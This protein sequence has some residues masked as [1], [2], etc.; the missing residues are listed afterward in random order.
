M[1]IFDYVY[2][3][4]YKCHKINANRGESYID[5][6]DWVKNEKTIKNPIN[7]EDNKCFQHAATVAFSREEIGNIPERIKKNKPFINKYKW[8]GINFP[9]DKDDR[10]RFEKN[11]VTIAP[12]VLYVRKEKI[13]SVYVS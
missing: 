11:N 6:P 13:Y 2:L 10:K 9:S 12:N 7:K 3:L 5:S 8:E 4:S 1:K